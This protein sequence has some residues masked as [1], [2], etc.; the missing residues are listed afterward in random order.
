MIHPGK[1]YGWA[2][3]TYGRN[4]VTGTKIGLGIESKE[5]IE[6]PIY[7]WTPSNAPF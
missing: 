4:Y 6:N 5:G 7:Q 3:V 2:D 1:N